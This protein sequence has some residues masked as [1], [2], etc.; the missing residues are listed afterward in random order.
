MSDPSEGTTTE[1]TELEE[2][3]PEEEP[4]EEEPAA[5]IE[6]A[7][8][9]GPVVEGLPSLSRVRKIDSIS[10]SA[11]AVIGLDT[12]RPSE[13]ALRGKASRFVRPP[14]AHRYAA[15]RGSPVR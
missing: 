4:Q 2:E 13:Q 7:K 15:A 10:R 3:E 1:I 8:V 14:T 9:A 6:K 12:R 11:C 5:A